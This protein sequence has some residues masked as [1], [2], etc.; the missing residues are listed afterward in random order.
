MILSTVLDDEH[1]LTWFLA[2]GAFPDAPNDSG[3]TAIDVAAWI[4]PPRV[5]ERLL[6]HGGMIGWTNALHMAVR[7]PKPGRS[8]VI[9]YL[10]EAGADIDSIENTSVESRR[11][12]SGFGTALH[13]AAREGREDL[14]RMLLEK[15]ADAEVRDTLGRTA[16][17]V[18]EEAA[19]PQLVPALSVVKRV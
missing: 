9:E 15:G 3:R 8:E 19:H 2:H 4:A 17:E 16:S 7:S 13:Y 6:Q 5:L 1:L 18:A 14:V 10:L 12:E 11:A